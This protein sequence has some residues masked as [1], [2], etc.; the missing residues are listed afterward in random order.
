MFCRLVF[1]L[2]AF[3]SRFVSVLPCIAH[4]LVEHLSLFDN[5]GAL[6]LPWLWLAL[7]GSAGSAGSLALAGSGWLWLWL[8]L[9]LT[10]IRC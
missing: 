2:L 10:S 6:A 1:N 7:A 8:W 4:L 9:A 3:Q 5:L